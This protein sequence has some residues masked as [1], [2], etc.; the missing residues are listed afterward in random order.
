MQP[1]LAAVLPPPAPLSSK[2]RFLTPW[3][4]PIEFKFDPATGTPTGHAT[5]E[6]GPFRIEIVRR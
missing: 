1:R 2:A 5:V 6:Q 4:A 3:G